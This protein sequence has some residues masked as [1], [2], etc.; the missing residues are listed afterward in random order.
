MKKTIPFSQLK[1]LYEAHSEEYDEAV[2]RVLRSGWYILGEEVEAFEN[3]FSAYT[4]IKY[5]AG[6]NSGLDALTLAL[7][8]LEIGAGDEVIVPANTFVATVL[9]ITASGA[10][11]VFV[12]SD[13]FHSINVDL[14]EKAIT[15]KT[16]CVIP[17]H[18]YGQA[19]DMD[20]LVGVARKNSLFVVEDCAQ[21]HGSTWRGQMTGTFGDIG[22]FSFFPTKNIGAFGD[23]GA[24]ITNEESLISR[25]RMF[26]NY[27]SKKKY[28]NEVP[29]INSRLDEIQAAL[30]RVRLK[31]VDEILKKRCE[32]AGAY[33][34]LINNE[35]IEL[36]KTRAGAAHTWHLFVISCGERDSLARFLSDNGIATQVHYPVP[37]YIS[38]VYAG[39]GFCR[40]SF[41]TASGQAESV[42]SLPL[43]YGMSRED[44]EYVAGTINN[45]YKLEAKNVFRSC[46]C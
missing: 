45:Y 1:S 12:D 22:C 25:V 9:A 20:S 19:C 8:V 18:L 23:A 2:L 6:L 37:P 3:E 21:S 13:N 44:A 30:L 4:G 11:P 31:H 15:P 16:R 17:V 26:R 27:G 36:P 46:S 14:I 5:C 40:D 43:Y 38:D 29:G 7:R 41:P 33:L 35:K 28:Y 32:I 10:T 39:M 42:L 34:D 24:I